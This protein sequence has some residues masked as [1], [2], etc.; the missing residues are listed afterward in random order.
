MEVWKDIPSYEGLYEASTY[1]RIRTKLGKITYTK[2]HGERKWKQRYLKNKTPNGRD[3]RVSLWKDGKEK[4]WLVHRLI[5]LTFIPQIPGKKFIN[6]IDGNP[7]NNMVSNLE[8][9]NYEENNNH[10][11][12]TGLMHTNFKIVLVKKKTGEPFYFRS[13]AK[14]SQFIGKNNGYLSREIKKGIK[15]LP[16]FHI[17]IP[18]NFEKGR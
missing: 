17:F 1:G 12:D 8:W 6:H 13:L 3:V 16:E 7:K 2:M 18:L 10:A 5:A 15:E 4:S 11:F 9:C 14:A